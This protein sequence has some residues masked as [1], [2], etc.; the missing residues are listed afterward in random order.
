MYFYRFVVHFIPWEGT[1]LL[2]LE[3][4]TQLI[5]LFLFLF[6]TVKMVC[7]EITAWTWEVGVPRAQQQPL[8]LLPGIIIQTVYNKKVV[9]FFFF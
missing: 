4:A 5:Y 9:F 7:S 1:G 2:K 6:H 8:G 3:G